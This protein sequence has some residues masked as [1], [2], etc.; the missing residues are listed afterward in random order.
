MSDCLFCK[1]VEKKIPAEVIFEDEKVVAFLDIKPVNPGH[2]LVIHRHHH[3]DIL[4][5]PEADMQDLIVGA[6]KVATILFEKGLADGVNI[7][8]NNKQA[9]NQLI[10]HAHLHVIPRKIGDGLKP[11]SHK[12][13]TPDGLQSIANQLRSK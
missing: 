13:S 8:M 11:W 7:G 5:T 10:L 3:V 9:A 2:A 6:K 12:D 1:I 4:D